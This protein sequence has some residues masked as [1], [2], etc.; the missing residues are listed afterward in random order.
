[1][2]RVAVMCHGVAKSLVI[3]SANRRDIMP[4]VTHIGLESFARISLTEYR[5]THK[6]SFKFK[7]GGD[8]GVV[9]SAAVLVLDMCRRLR[10]SILRGWCPPCIVHRALH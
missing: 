4:T 9:S 7:G 2:R 8:V 5:I 6:T 1:M 3:F 10:R